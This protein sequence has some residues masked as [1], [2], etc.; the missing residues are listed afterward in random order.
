VARWQQRRPGKTDPKTTVCTDCHGEHR[1]K[2]RTVQW[3]KTTGKLLR[4]GG[5]R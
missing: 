1:L 3:D 5:A 2:L 4:T